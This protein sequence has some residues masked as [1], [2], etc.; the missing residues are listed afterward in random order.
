VNQTSLVTGNGDLI[1][2]SVVHPD[3]V[4]FE[5]N[6]RLMWLSPDESAGLR[7]MLAGAEEYA[8]GR[9]AQPVPNMAHH[10]ATPDTIRT[11][12]D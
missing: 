5:S 9:P 10:N 2:V 3:R 4:R 7:A 12:A 6:G 1:F 8:R 11:A